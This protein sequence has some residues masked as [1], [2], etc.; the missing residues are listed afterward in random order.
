[1]ARPHITE[2]IE[3]VGDEKLGYTLA[4]NSAD[5]YD[6]Y[7]TTKLEDCNEKT[8]ISH[9]FNEQDARKAMYSLYKCALENPNGVKRYDVLCTNK[10]TKKSYVKASFRKKEDALKYVDENNNSSR[11]HTFALIE[12]NI[13]N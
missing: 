3:V 11:T 7:T 8:S 5:Y 4:K 9:Y 2:I 6:I 13:N 1:M 12:D 10:R